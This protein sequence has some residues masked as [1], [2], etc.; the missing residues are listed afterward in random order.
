MLKYGRGTAG[1]VV[2]FKH[3]AKHLQRSIKK[4]QVAD[5]VI[6]HVQTHVA[7]YIPGREA[8][9]G[10]AEKCKNEHLTFWASLHLALPLKKMMH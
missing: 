4:Q 3:M 9:P 7:G 6:R 2:F 8:K 1:N 10:H 5:L